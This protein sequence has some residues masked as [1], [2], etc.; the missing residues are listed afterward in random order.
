MNTI[1]HTYTGLVD[2]FNFVA[3]HVQTEDI[4]H[5]LAMIGRYGGA[6]PVFYSVA[7][8]AVRVAHLVERISGDPVTTL[9]ALHHDSAEAYIGDQ[10]SPIKHALHVATDSGLVP[11]DSFEIQL[12]NTIL[13]RYGLPSTTDPNQR[14]RWDLIEA[15]DAT[16]LRVELRGLFDESQQPTDLEKTIPPLY[17]PEITRPE[18]ASWVMAKSLFLGHHNRLMNAI[19]KMREA[20]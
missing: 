5:H 3:D 14:E 17:R 4:A 8:H 12:L 11:F 18:C 10:R 20:A 9:M 13:R 15:A 2:P 7:Q 1:C 6:C 19:S 16:M